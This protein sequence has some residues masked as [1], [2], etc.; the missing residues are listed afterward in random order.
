MG[1]DARRPIGKGLNHRGQSRARENATVEQ[2]WEHICVHRGDKFAETTWV[3]YLQMYKN[4]IGPYFGPRVATSIGPQDLV[5]YR[6]KRRGDRNLWVADAGGIKP[7]TRNREVSLLRTILAWGVTHGLT[8]YDP[9]AGYEDKEPENNVRENV[10]SEEDLSRV[11]AFLD[12][13]G[14]E[15]LRAYLLVC[16]DSG[17]RRSEAISLR[18]DHISYERREIYVSRRT[19]KLNLA[20]TTILSDRTARALQEIERESPWVFFNRHTG[21][22][23]RPDN[24]L[25]QWHDCQRYL[26]IIGPDGLFSLHDLRRSFVTIARRRGIPET[27]IMSLSGHRSHDVF[28]RYAIVGDEDRAAFR[29]RWERGHWAETAEIQARKRRKSNAK[30]PFG[31][32]NTDDH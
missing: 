15:M 3:T 21:R 31:R 32:G 2:I 22:P 29:E 7:A 9:V 4:H 20:R 18:W 24:F 12:V 8:Q 13:P 25:K 11:L 19:A 28:R 5:E 6:T 23:Y 17:L 27:V 1:W 16:A 30:L 14:R 10:L 26:G